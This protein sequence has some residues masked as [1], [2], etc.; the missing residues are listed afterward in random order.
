MK[1]IVAYLLM[2]SMIL[3][4]NTMT[5]AAQVK[6]QSSVAEHSSEVV[7]IPDKYLLNAMLEQGDQNGDGRLT[8]EEL[9]SVKEI[10]ISDADKNEIDFTGIEYATNLKYVYINNA[11]KLNHTEELK[12][13][14]KIERL[15]VTGV[16]DNDIENIAKMESLTDLDISGSFKNINGLEQLKKLEYL[17]LK[18]DELEDIQTLKN[19]DNLDELYINECKKIKDI[20]C[21]KKGAYSTLGISENIPA[22]QVLD[23]EDFGDV[24]IQKGNFMEMFESPVEIYSDPDDNP[25]SMSIFSYRSNNIKIIDKDGKAVAKGETDVT[26]TVNGRENEASRT[27]HV[28]VQ[29]GSDIDP[30]GETKE[31]LPILTGNPAGGQISINAIYE[32]G[33][34]YDLTNNGEKVANDAKSYMVDYVYDGN[35][36]YMFKTKISKSGNLYTGLETGDM[37]LQ[38]F[39]VK[40]V[41]KNFF[42]TNDNTLYRINEKNQ[43][44]KIDE[45]VEDI[46][47]FDLYLLNGRCLVLHKDGVLTEV[48]DFDFK[49]QNVKKIAA[50]NYIVQNDG[51]MLFIDWYEEYGESSSKTRK[52][53]DTEMTVVAME[54]RVYQYTLL[55]K[56]QTLYI[57]DEGKLH[58]IAD[59]V[60]KVTPYSCVYENINGE[61][62]AYERESDE[63]GKEFFITSKISCTNEKFTGVTQDG[64]VY[65]EGEKILTDVVNCKFYMKES[66]YFMVRKDGTVWA[67]WFPYLA[68]KVLNYDGEKVEPTPEPTP[69]PTPTPTP[70]PIPAPTPSSGTTASSN[71]EPQ[72]I[73]V[74]KISFSAI[75]TKI[76]AGKKIKL[77]TLINPQNATNKTLKWTTSNNKLATVDKNGVVT[78]NKKAGGKTVKITAEATDGSGKKATFTIKIMKGS[79]KKIKISGKKTVK[80]GKTLKLKA[81]V[82]AGKGANK[83]LKWTS[84]NTKYATVSSGKVKALKAGKKKSVKI[85]AMATDGSGKSKTVTI[86]IK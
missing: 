19:L 45:N 14:T 31:Q 11:K 47:A 71:A 52:V 66:M 28:K 12:Q 81:K 26:I 35:K 84:S 17:R 46:K 36:Y 48:K 83:T 34:V 2:I 78:L 79:V 22:D 65:I 23:Y 61:Y 27:I 39:T 62:Y 86:K 60:K 37:K 30:A 4:N 74:N 68:E 7:N 80:A 56:N 58:K 54:D 10:Y 13:L 82:K 44:E 33:N 43:A 63:K 55:L 9:K 57:Y 85:T 21:L 67:Y 42:I 69:R 53:A 73:K 16:A 76:A 59:D 32:N 29:D 6:S 64:T 3:S 72:Q 40:K 5:I 38:N 77:T 1:Q 49:V 51:S 24:T 41:D 75:S 8:T 50:Y 18:S 20:S 15:T 25:D 70:Q